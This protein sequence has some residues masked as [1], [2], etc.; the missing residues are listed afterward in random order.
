MLSALWFWFGAR[1]RHGIHSP[2]VYAFLERTL[3]AR[4]RRG[5]NPEQQLLLAACEHFGPKRVGVAASAAGLGA[6][7][8]PALPL[9]SWGSR[10]FD[11]YIAGCP[12]PEL[13]AR[14]AD[15]ALWH[16]DSVLFVGGLRSGPEA[17]RSW[18][19]LCA[20]PQLRVSLETYRAGLLFFRSQQAPQH[21]KIRLK[22]SI[23]KRS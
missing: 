12:G 2:F 6:W 20:L 15:P 10:P 3:Y 19:R 22:S 18:K 5:C 16:N 8:K 21:F 23:F 4:R 9:A 1:N 11:L 14:L 17:R 13:E 7:L